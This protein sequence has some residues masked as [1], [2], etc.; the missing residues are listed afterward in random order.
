MSGQP[1]Y[2][3]TSFCP[4][5]CLFLEQKIA[6]MK[7]FVRQVV[8]HYLF[9]FGFQT[10]FGC[11]SCVQG[12]LRLNSTRWQFVSDHAKDLLRKMLRVNFEERLT[13]DEALAHPWIREREHYAP[14]IHLVSSRKLY[15]L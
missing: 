2:Y 8:D 4:E 10:N 12:K 9:S 7:V 11:L 3:F 13:V 15:N 1:G 6:Y 5:H 14:K